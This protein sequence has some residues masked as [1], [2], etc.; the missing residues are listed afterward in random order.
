[1]G[2]RVDDRQAAAEEVGDIGPGPGGPRRGGVG[3]Y[4]SRRVRR[5]GSVG[6][7]ARAGGG[8][9]GQEGAHA[10]Q[11]PRARAPRPQWALAAP[12][13]LRGRARAAGL[14]RPRTASTGH[15]APGPGTRTANR[16]LHAVAPAGGAP[17]MLPPAAPE[18]C[19]EPRTA[20][21]P[22]AP[23]IPPA[24]LA[25]L[26]PPPPLCRRD[27][28]RAQEHQP[29]EGDGR[30]RRGPAAARPPPPGAA[31]ARAGARQPRWVQAGSP[32]TPPA[33]CPRRRAARYSALPAPC[34][35]TPARRPAPPSRRPARRPPGRPHWA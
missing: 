16:A 22:D 12:G 27:P 29:G 25:L 17:G 6:P 19:K 4:G 13:R 21:L 2:G 20:V 32:E 10:E 34:W 15:R 30:G 9:E 8:R 33:R 24:P 18:S 11:R 1:V 14:S 3:P 28:E 23:G 31:A 26:A 5:D 7:A 35:R